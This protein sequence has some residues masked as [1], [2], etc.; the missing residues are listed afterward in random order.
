MVSHLQ[1]VAL[2]NIRLWRQSRAPARDDKPPRMRTSFLFPTPTFLSGMSSV[3]DLAGHPGRYH[4]SRTGAE[5]D[6]KALY[7]DYRMIGQDI[8][9]AT[10][11]FL[12]SH[13]EAVP[14]T[15]QRLFNPDKAERT[16]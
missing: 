8:E 2:S 15:Q 5:A 7:S 3:L 11:Y 1:K 10:R 14:A 16:Q 12:T 9:E 13:P 6:A 4:F